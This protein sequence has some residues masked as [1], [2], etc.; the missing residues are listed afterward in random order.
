MEAGLLFSEACLFGW[1]MALFSPVSSC[2]LPSVWIFISISHEDTSP[3]VLGAPQR[4]H[5]NLDALFK[6]LKLR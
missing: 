5:F 3:T 2:G 6:I 4:P 1:E